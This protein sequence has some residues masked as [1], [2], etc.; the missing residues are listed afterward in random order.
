MTVTLSQKQQCA[1][2]AKTY[3]LSLIFLFGSTV[4]GSAAKESDL[5]IAVLPRHAF[6]PQ[7]ALALI[8][9]L[10]QALHGNADLTVL[11]RTTPIVKMEIVRAS[12]LLYGSARDAAVFRMR[13]IAEYLDTAP[14]RALTR[15]YL[16]RP[17]P[18]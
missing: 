10:T 3:D 17:L 6:S 4:K 9:D 15:K 12:E 18:V 13:A 14:L 1:D 11:S 2:I 16:A 5:D 7:E 8:S